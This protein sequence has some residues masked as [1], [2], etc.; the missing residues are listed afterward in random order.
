VVSIEE[1]DVEAL[2]E[3]RAARNVL[4]TELTSTVPA[5]AGSVL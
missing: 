5:L 3:R 4:A 1:L 2:P